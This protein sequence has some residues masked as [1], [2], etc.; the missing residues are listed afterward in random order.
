M[1]TSQVLHKENKRTGEMAPGY[2][3]CFVSMSSDNQISSFH[4][5]T[6]CLCNSS[7]KRQEG[8]SEKESRGPKLRV[9]KDTG[10]CQYV[11]EKDR[12]R[13]EVKVFLS[14]SFGRW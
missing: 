5:S 6:V 1:I 14:L 10:S 7:P 11:L 13:G 8:V 2:S 3:A 4:V 12:R 9:F